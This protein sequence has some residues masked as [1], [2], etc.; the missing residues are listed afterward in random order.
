MAPHQRAG[1]KPSCKPHHGLQHRCALL[2]S[3]GGSHTYLSLPSWENPH[4]FQCCLHSGDSH[5]GEKAEPGAA[6]AGLFRQSSPAGCA[7]A[8]VASAAPCGCAAHAA[9]TTPSVALSPV[10]PAGSGRTRSS[11]L[12]FTDLVECLA[13]AL[14]WKGGC[15]PFRKN[16]YGPLDAS[17]RCPFPALPSAFSPEVQLHSQHHAC[18]PGSG[19]CSQATQT[20]C[21]PPRRK[22]VLGRS[23]AKLGHGSRDT[24]AR[25][26]LRCPTPGRSRE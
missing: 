6:H 25:V 3:W 2:G 7:R 23:A 8:G 4:L 15:H 13:V 16:P 14:S 24:Q 21:E 26:T 22:V 17:T 11:A 18:S 19:G 9:R 10:S 5:S 20:G 12:Y 1:S